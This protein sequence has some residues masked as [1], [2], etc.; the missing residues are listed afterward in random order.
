M[1][2]LGHFW[3]ADS[4]GRHLP[5]EPRRRPE[6]EECGPRSG[7]REACG[8]VTHWVTLGVPF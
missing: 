4:D 6:S 1:M 8:K 2:H 7:G 5:N 3:G